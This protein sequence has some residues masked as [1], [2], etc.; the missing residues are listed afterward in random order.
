MYGVSHLDTTHTAR[1]PPLGVFRSNRLQQGGRQ[2]LD[3]NPQTTENKRVYSYLGQQGSLIQG[4]F[5]WL[6]A[7][8]LLRG[9]ANSVSTD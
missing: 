4:P 3:H 1:G 8:D 9:H 5:R 6:E 7:F 2:V